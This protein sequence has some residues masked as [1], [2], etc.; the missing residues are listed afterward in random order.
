ML[1]AAKARLAATDDG[2]PADCR[3][4]WDLF[5]ALATWRPAGGMSPAPL[6]ASDVQAFE[7]LHDLTLSPW[8]IAQLKRWDLQLLAHW[9]AQQAEA[10]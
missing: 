7:A 9:R 1:D 4:L 10:T 8:Q 5:E 6:T 3:A 2:L